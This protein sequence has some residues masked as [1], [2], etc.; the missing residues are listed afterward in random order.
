MAIQ[1]G[2]L[3]APPVHDRSGEFSIPNLG[4]RPVPQAVA[5]FNQK[6]WVIGTDGNGN[7]VQTTL[8]IEQ[9]D[10]NGTKTISLP[11]DAK[12]AG[13]WTSTTLEIPGTSTGRPVTGTRCAATPLGDALYLVWSD[14]VAF[15]FGGPAISTLTASRFSSTGDNALRWS[16]ALALQDMSGAPLRYQSSTDSY[17]PTNVAATPFGTDTVIVACACLPNPA[18]SGAP[19]VYIGAFDVTQIDQAANTWQA[20]TETWIP[21]RLFQSLGLPLQVTIDWFNSSDGPDEYPP[22]WLW[23]TVSQNDG[24]HRKQS[25]GTFFLPLDA[26]GNPTSGAVQDGYPI[27]PGT[28]SYGY[29]AARDPA[30]R[31]RTYAN[32][33]DKRT[34]H[35]DTYNTYGPIN[36]DTNQPPLPCS[37]E[38]FTAAPDAITPSVAF[39]TDLNNGQDIDGRPGKEYPVWEF[40][41]YPAGEMKCQV[42]LLGY[43]QVLPN[44]AAIKPVKPK[45]T[46]TFIVA[47]IVDGPIPIPHENIADYSYGDPEQNLGTVSYST[48]AG[49]SLTHTVSNSW[50]AGFKSD[51]KSTKGVGPAW[52]VALAGGTGYTHGTV[53]TTSTSTSHDQDSRLNRYTSR[54][55]Q[56]LLP[57]GTLFCTDATMQ[58]TAYRFVD[59]EHQPISDGTNAN[60]KNQSPLFVTVETSFSDAGVQS[61]VPYAVTPGDL[62]SYQP[63]RLNNRMKALGA[64]TDYF[65]RIIVPNAYKF[66]SDQNYLEASW[67]PDGDEQTQFQATN[68]AFVEQTW[69]FDASIYGGVSGGEGLSI[70]GLGENFSYEFLVGGSFSSSANTTTDTT[71]GWGIAVRWPFGPPYGGGPKAMASYT[72]RLYFLPPPVPSS[73]LPPNYWVQ[74][75]R[76]FAKQAPL[77]PPNTF[78]ALT[79]EQIDPN[80]S[81]WKIVYVVTKWETV[82]PPVERYTYSRPAA[83]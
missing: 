17:I 40:V 22:Y 53:K 50:T 83:G 25:K 11:D 12:L 72:F 39:F 70:F 74:E 6:L 73:G 48:S 78:P 66:K 63:D 13:N 59:P 47:G 23:V 19:G 54:P 31:V 14:L 65:E 20:R 35:V 58:A 68:T 26:A 49:Q 33:W 45:V 71:N 44:Y 27:Y 57:A 16:P 61:F 10:A 36:T 21:A 69:T 43:A 81:A 4:H 7:M 24:G 77:P 76:T 46:S 41:V 75:L 2:E 28:D 1:S 42:N 34:L 5:Y 51:G 80:A 56:Q 38:T 29:F 30:G 3:N 37:S 8:S 60:G 15:P 67:G 32:F 18:D 52:N 64:G 55:N 79:P 62:R 9:S 82:G